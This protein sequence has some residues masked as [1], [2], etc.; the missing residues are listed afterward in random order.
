MELLTSDKICDVA[1]H[2]ESGQKRVTITGPVINCAK[3]IV[4]LITGGGKADV[5]AT[6]V[7]GSGT[8]YPATHVQPKS[9]ELVFFLD[10]AAA[11]KI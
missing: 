2:P 3:Q 8:Q 10:E 7:D 6:V 9:G 4:F 11:A 1:V 5:L